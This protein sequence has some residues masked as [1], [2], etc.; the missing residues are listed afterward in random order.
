MKN[1][2]TFSDWVRTV[3]RPVMRANERKQRAERRRSSKAWKIMR[4]TLKELGLL[5]VMATVT[6]GVVYC[7]TGDITKALHIAG[8][9]G[10][11]KAGAAA[12]YGRI[13]G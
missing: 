5:A 8:I 12:A 13:V 11:I 2:M 9:A 10:P 4:A 1:K 6:L 3:E 7:E